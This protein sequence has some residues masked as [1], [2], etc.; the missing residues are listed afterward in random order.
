MSIEYRK[1]DLLEQED[2]NFIIHNANCFCVMGSGVARAIAEK[3]PEAVEADNQT[4]KGDPNKLGCFSYA[5]TKDGKMIANLYAQFN[6]GGGKRNLNYE[7]FYG[8]LEAIHNQILDSKDKTKVY[9]VGMP[10][11]IGCGLAGGS[12]AIT[13]EMIKDIFRDSKIK[14][15]ICEL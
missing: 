2:V 5:K 9:I 15:V 4:T 8:G 14:L 12:W 6:Y 11:F 10:K 7:A 3:Y 13:H 1:G